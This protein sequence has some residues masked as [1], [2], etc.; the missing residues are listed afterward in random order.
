MSSSC[1]RES[2]SMLIMF[3][4]HNPVQKISFILAGP[5]MIKSFKEIT[6]ILMICVSFGIGIPLSSF[7]TYG[8]TANDNSL[9]AIDDGPSSPAIIFPA[10]FA[11][12]GTS[13]TSIYVSVNTCIICY[14]GFKYMNHLIMCYIYIYE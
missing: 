8:P 2:T 11:F 10:P 13:Y 6:S 5:T 14:N 1:I 3:Y 7:Y 9:G 4:I 12:F